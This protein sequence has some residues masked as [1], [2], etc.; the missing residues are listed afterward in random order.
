MA[1]YAF[2][3]DIH[4]KRWLVCNTQKAVTANYWNLLT[5]TYWSAYFECPEAFN[6]LVNLHTGLENAVPF[7]AEKNLFRGNISWNAYPLNSKCTT[8]KQSSLDICGQFNVHKATHY[9]INVTMVHYCGHEPQF[10]EMQYMMY[11]MY[12]YVYVCVCVYVCMYFIF[13]GWPIDPSGSSTMGLSLKT[14]D[15]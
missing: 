9:V 1:R 2:V 10:K 11:I 5:E 13:W 15:Y 14:T 6:L 8:K 4:L 3:K 12:V 7:L